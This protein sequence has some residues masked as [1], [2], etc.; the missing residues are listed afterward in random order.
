MDIKKI[1]K[2]V[3]S[4]LQKNLITIDKMYDEDNTTYVISNAIILIIDHD[5]QVIN[6]CF[7][8]TMKPD[9]ASLVSLMLT[10]INYTMVINSS[11][12]QDENGRVI[13][14]EEAED[15]FRQNITNSIVKDFINSQNQLHVL[16]M[17]TPENSSIN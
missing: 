11:F 9:V 3:K 4:T 17:I 7:H 1:K 12:I 2:I 16:N 13:D 10:K 15:F 14:G 6:L 5:K 8:I